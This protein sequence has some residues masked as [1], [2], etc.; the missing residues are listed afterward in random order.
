[1]SP[2]ASVI[3]CTRNRARLLEGCLLSLL[4]DR[5]SVDWEVIVVDN[6]S[7]DE[8]ASIVTRCR[9]PEA[10][11]PF[12]YLVE[13]QLGLSHARNRGVAAAAGDYL[14]FT[15][16][17][18]FVQPG[19]VDA[20]CAGFSDPAVAAVG[21]RVLPKWPSRPPRW[22][23]GR[24]TGLL[25]LTDYGDAPRDLIGDE[26]PI[27]ANMA[28]RAS[29]LDGSVTPFDPRL[30]HHGSKY[31]AFEELDL[32]LE[33]REAGRLVYRPDAVVLH[34]IL[35][36]RMTWQGMRRA[37]VDNGFGSRRAERLRG[38]AP[39]ALRASV[40]GLGRA[41]VSALEQSRRNGGRDDVDPEAAGEE[42]RRWWVLG[43]WIEI[44]FGDSR[45]GGWLLARVV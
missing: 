4:A 10:G 16:D 25:A 38:A 33:L 7:T 28:I 31:F 24:H 44:V 41:Y 11:I 8:T 22:L 29:V 37:S 45:L 43:R 2:K 13:E 14:L 1:M 21:G 34:R 20:L 39:I 23:A 42:F 17:D 15:D 19:W 18:V 26:F 30:G 40:P 5:P 6:A 35:P 36:H 9:A 12:D 3:V 27:G 32:F